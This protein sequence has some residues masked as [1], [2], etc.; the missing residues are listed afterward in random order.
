MDS[1]IG[2]N[3]LATY[4]HPGP[5]GPFLELKSEPTKPPSP[6][7]SALLRHNPSLIDLCTFNSLCERLMENS[8]S[9]SPSPS[10]SHSSYKPLVNPTELNFLLPPVTKLDC[11]EH[12]PVTSIKSINPPE[13]PASPITSVGECSPNVSSYSSTPYASPKQELDDQSDSPL[14]ESNMKVCSIIQDN[15]Q[16]LNSTSKTGNCE[17]AD[18]SIKKE[19]TSISNPRRDSF[20]FESK[21]KSVKTTSNR[22]SLTSPILHQLL[23]SPTKLNDLLSTTNQNDFDP[24]K[25]PQYRPRFSPHYKP[26]TSPTDSARKM[27]SETSNNGSING[28]ILHQ[29]TRSPTLKEEKINGHSRTLSQSDHSHDESMIDQTIPMKSNTPKRSI[30]LLNTENCLSKRR[31][32][33]IL[34]MTF[35]QHDYCISYPANIPRCIDCQTANPMDFS[36]HLAGCRFQNCRI[37]KQTDE[38]NFQFEGFTTLTTATTQDMEI[39]SVPN[40]CGQPPLNLVDANYIFM[41]IAKLFSLLFLHE[42]G[43]RLVNDEKKIIWKRYM[44]GWREV[45]D[46]C[47]TTLFNHHY[48]CQQCGYMICIECSNQY[49]QLTFEKRKKLKRLCPHENS[50]KLSEFIPWTILSKLRNSVIDYLSELKLDYT[51]KLY[52]STKTEHLSAFI[53]SL[54]MKRSHEARDARKLWSSDDSNADKNIE[55]YC[56]GRLPVFNEWTSEN[57]KEFFRKVWSSSC[58]VLVKQVHRNLSKTLWQPEAFKEH[59]IDH[60]ETP[61][62]WDCETLTPI[63]TNEQILT[64]FWDGFERLDLRLRDEE[65]R[66][67]PRILKLKDWPTKKDFASV[68]PTLLH[69]LMTNI[70]FSDYT[71][72]S[73]KY[74]GVTYYGGPMNIVERLPN[75]LVKP[76][77][78][79]KLYIAYSQLTSQATRKAG[80]TNLHIDVSDAVNVLVYVGIGGQGENGEDKE[81]EMRQVEAEILDSNID[82]AQLE[83][84]RNGERP[85]ALWHLFRSDD[86]KKVREYI[87][88]AQRKAP[89][90]DSIH[91]Q[92]AYLEK[93]DLDK[94]REW[95]KVESYPI[96]Q[97]EGDAVFIPSGAP[98]QVKNLHSCI[99]IAE[100]FV[101]P[102]NLDRCFITTNEFRSL[103]KTHSNH[104]DI[105]QAK[106]I[107]YYGTRDALNSLLDSDKSSNSI[108]STVNT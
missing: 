47:Y 1:Y 23:T 8:S 33:E 14:V 52:Q 25:S 60:R 26:P 94:L 104:A 77:L 19:S 108:T 101:S 35:T 46:E 68:F 67:R 63:Q 27:K 4:L 44:A 30:E 9:S 91:D 98:H 13:T 100:D 74:E 38:E 90:S 93:D 41:Q 86:A 102:E 89:G 37:L 6:V 36:M 40:S 22:S 29:S 11:T 92:T 82:E 3:K 17:T 24:P 97:F 64:Q 96:L 103:S 7:T 106:N 76:D 15:H 12:S 71:R 66:N 80:T 65:N 49:A 32:P 105:L 2:Q 61:A 79:P 95:S 85:G 53:K 55:F 18:S 5:T 42:Q 69:D 39:L 56:H 88:R 45:C 72:R 10:S 58:P 99:K 51:I 54:K 16:Q 107:L 70:P 87:G 59:M 43:E 50:F 21:S 28:N 75:F 48:M 57:A 20:P 34:P 81:E 73:Y 31:C 78:G 62:L 84:L 83:R